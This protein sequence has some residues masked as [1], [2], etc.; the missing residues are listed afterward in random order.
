MSNSVTEISA[1][2]RANSLQT[3]A[4]N[5]VHFVSQWEALVVDPQECATR[6]LRVPRCSTVQPLKIRL[7]LRIALLDPM[8][9]PNSEPPNI[10]MSIIQPWH[11]V[12]FAD[13]YG[14]FIF[15]VTRARCARSECPSTDK[16][17]F[18]EPNGFERVIL[19]T[20]SLKSELSNEL[21]H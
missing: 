4:A 3:N 21:F 11:S 2:Q 5:P 19:C 10:T 1:F 9:H 6:V 17:K 14:D 7:Y 13:G 16:N 20:K 18:V 12:R 15:S 8:Q